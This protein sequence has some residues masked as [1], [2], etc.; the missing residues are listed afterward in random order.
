MPVPEGGRLAGETALVSGSTSGLGKV[1]ARVFAA[2]GAAVCVTGRNPD[3]GRQVSADI[4]AAGGQAVFVA[5]DLGSVEECARLVAEAAAALGGLTVLVNN[6][7]ANSASGSGGRDGPVADVDPAAWDRILRVNLGAPAFLCRAAI[8]KMRERG[9]GAI[10][11]ISSRAAERGTPRLAAYAASKGGM[12]ALTRSIAVDY[13]ADG[14][15][16]NTIQPGYILHEDRDRELD[17]AR[18]QR[19]AGM[20]LGALGTAEDV[21]LAAVYLASRESAHVTGITLPV[22]GGSTAARGLVLG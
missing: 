20:V 1:I 11:N 12:N 7:V 3:R 8:P 4:E 9:H 13:A 14:I 6:A 15:R 5:A 10:V 17:A 16:C 18:R 22:D 2:E 21:A 19:L